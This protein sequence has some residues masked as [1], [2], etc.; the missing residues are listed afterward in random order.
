[1]GGRNAAAANG[2]CREPK[3]GKPGKNA[4]RNDAAAMDLAFGDDGG[5]EEERKKFAKERPAR[6]NIRPSARF[7]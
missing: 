3:P 1:M 4:K 6:P 5:E 7:C 2:I